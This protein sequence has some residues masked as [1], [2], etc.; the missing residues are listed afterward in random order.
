MTELSK[1]T[2]KYR[3]G[4]QAGVKSAVAARAIALRRDNDVYAFVEME[5]EKGA[6]RATIDAARIFGLQVGD[7][8][9]RTLPAITA[10][11]LTLHIV[12]GDA[13][14]A[15]VEYWL[16]RHLAPNM[17]A[18]TRFSTSLLT[19]VS[20]E[21]ISLEFP[22]HE[23]A[24]WAFWRLHGKTIPRHAPFP[25]VSFDVQWLYVSDKTAQQAAQRRAGS[26]AALRLAQ[27]SFLQLL[28]SR[29]ERWVFAK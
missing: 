27:K 13:V 25:D 10:K 18:R 29:A 12:G 23:A 14:S 5:T 6:Q 7:S 15:E 3:G 11:A 4:R 8:M 26:E 16:N 20:P 9:C 21:A 1:S 24:V 2:K 19:E 22:S 17:F 28:A